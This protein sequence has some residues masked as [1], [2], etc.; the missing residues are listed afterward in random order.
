M[1]T[2]NTG[3]TMRA[4]M[5]LLAAVAGVRAGAIGSRGG[6]LTLNT[7]SNT[8]LAGTPATSAVLS[9]TATELN[10]SVP[11]GEPASAELTGTMAAVPGQ[12]YTFTC[13]FGAATFVCD[14]LSALHCCMPPCLPASLPPCLCW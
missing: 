6:S 3:N 9:V 1:H 2:C 11:S 4:A 14:H 12:A 8:A 7:F 13:D 5:C 10:F